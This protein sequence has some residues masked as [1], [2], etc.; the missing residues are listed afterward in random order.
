MNKVTFIEVESFGEIETHAIID[1]GNGEFTSM[2]KA[3]Y[4]EQQAANDT[5]EL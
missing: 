1:K 5:N 3:T 2:S 4:D